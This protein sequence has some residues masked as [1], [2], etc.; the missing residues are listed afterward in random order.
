MWRKNTRD[1]NG[2]GGFDSGDGVDIN[3]NYPYKWGSCNGSSGST[4]AQDYRGTAPA[5]EPETQV[6]MDLV[7]AGSELF[8]FLNAKSKFEYLKALSI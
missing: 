4:W 3:R 7:K 5:S 2:S 8:I 6:M 1:N